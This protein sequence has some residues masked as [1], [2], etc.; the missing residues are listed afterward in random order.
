M[1]EILSGLGDLFWVKALKLFITTDSGSPMFY[2]LFSENPPVWFGLGIPPLLCA[3]SL[4][5]GIYFYC[6]YDCFG[7]ANYPSSP[8]ILFSLDMAAKKPGILLLLCDALIRIGA[9]GFAAATRLSGSFA[10]GTAAAAPP[11][12]F[13]PIEFLGLG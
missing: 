5:L 2:L 11:L 6:Y 13:S 8:S 9:A 7:N 1:F 4:D 10:R 12:G 3:L